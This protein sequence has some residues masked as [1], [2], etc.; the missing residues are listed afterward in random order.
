MPPK[1]GSH[2]MRKS[3]IK[4]LETKTFS[5]ILWSVLQD[6]NLVFAVTT[7]SLEIACSF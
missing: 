2:M 3:A 6:K 1:I 4:I 5:T 7:Q